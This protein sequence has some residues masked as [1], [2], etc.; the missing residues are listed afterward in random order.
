MLIARGF[1]VSFAMEDGRTVKGVGEI[2]HDESGVDWPSDSALVVAFKKTG[3]PLGRVSK[4]A[5]RHFGDDYEPLRGRVVLPP[6]RLSSWKEI[7]AVKEIFYDRRGEHDGA[8]AH[9]F[10]GR[11]FFGSAKELPILYRRGDALR[12]EPVEWDWSGAR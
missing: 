4:A 12:L 2:L 1:H 5:R 9:A 6:R 3:K 10:G 8:F 7:G 11:K